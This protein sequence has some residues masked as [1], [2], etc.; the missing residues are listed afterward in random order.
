M[1]ARPTSSVAKRGSTQRF[2]T[3]SVVAP[4]SPTPAGRLAARMNPITSQLRVEGERHDRALPDSD[5]VA[6]VPGDDLVRAGVLDD[7]RPDEHAR[8]RPLAT[9]QLEIR[10][11]AVDLASVAVA[12]D[13]DVQDA[14]PGLV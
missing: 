4:A 8:E 10:L 1:R 12:A 6:L 14:E 13:G 2:R 5:R 3:W 7:R 9:G 11:E